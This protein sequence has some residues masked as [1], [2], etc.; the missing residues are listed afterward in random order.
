MS[1]RPDEHNDGPVPLFEVRPIGKLAGIGITA[2]FIAVVTIIGEILTGGLPARMLGY[3]QGFVSLPLG[4]AAP[5][6]AALTARDSIPYALPVL[7]VSLIY[8]VLFAV[9]L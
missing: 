7:G 2:G 5:I 6:I 1:D 8:W 3:S 9:F 4:V